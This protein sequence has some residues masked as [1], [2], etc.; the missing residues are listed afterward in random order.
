MKIN[1][2]KLLMSIKYLNI[3][4][5]YIEIIVFFILINLLLFTFVYK[6]YLQLRIQ[7]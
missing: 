2:L 3:N 5:C 4:S 1:I 7:W 6:Q